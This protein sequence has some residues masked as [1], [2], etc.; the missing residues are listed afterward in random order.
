MY[1]IGFQINNKFE[2]RDATF[3]GCIDKTSDRIQQMAKIGMKSCLGSH[4]YEDKKNRRIRI[5][6]WP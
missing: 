6:L 4:R 5:T 3:M 1:C 2:I